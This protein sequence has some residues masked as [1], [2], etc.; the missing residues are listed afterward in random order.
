MNSTSTSI[1]DTFVRRSASSDTRELIGYISAD[2]TQ[3]I[4]FAAII[5]KIISIINK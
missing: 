5:V 2:S 3:R 1:I 4:N